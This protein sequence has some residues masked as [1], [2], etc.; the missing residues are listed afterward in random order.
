MSIL[1]PPIVVGANK[2]FEQDVLGRSDFGQ[3]LLNLVFQSRN[4][5]VISLDEVG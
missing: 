4:E 5:L 1:T 2:A 3:S